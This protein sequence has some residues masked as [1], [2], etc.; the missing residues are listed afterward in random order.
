VFVVK[1]RKIGLLFN[2]D[3]QFLALV[4]GKNIVNA[5]VDMGAEKKLCPYT[6]L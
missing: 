4:A 2:K 3:L 6:I 1:G 5:I